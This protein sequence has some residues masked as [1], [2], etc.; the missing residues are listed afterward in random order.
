MN[1]SEEQ[2]TVIGPYLHESLFIVEEKR[3][4]IKGHCEVFGQ[5]F[6]FQGIKMLDKI[7]W[8]SVPSSQD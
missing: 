2:K 8:V 5:L 3:N 1:I 4:A 7:N 6:F